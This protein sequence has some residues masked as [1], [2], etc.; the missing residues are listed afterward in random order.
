MCKKK[1]GVFLTLVAVWA[2]LVLWP[3][4]VAG[5]IEINRGAAGYETPM[6]ALESIRDSTGLTLPLTLDFWAPTETDMANLDIWIH[7]LHPLA[8]LSNDSTWAA[9]AK[10]TLIIGRVYR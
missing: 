10:D 5:G 2:A 6:A 7:G 9:V 4:Q 8:H 3:T 1:A